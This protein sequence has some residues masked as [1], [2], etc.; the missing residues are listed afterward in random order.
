MAV[1][2]AMATVAS[3]AVDVTTLEATPY[4]LVLLLHWGNI[5]ATNEEFLKFKR[6]GAEHCEKFGGVAGRPQLSFNI[7]APSGILTILCV[8]K[9]SPPAQIPPAETAVTEFRDCPECPEMVVVPVGSFK[10]GDLSGGVNRNE[11]PVHQITFSRLFAVG[12]Y[13]VTFDQWDACVSD[14]GCKTRPQDE[15]WGRSNRPV[16][17]VSWNDAR[18]YV[19]WLSRKTGKPYRLLSEAEWEY[20]ARAGT[21]TE[22]YWGNSFS[23]DYVDIMTRRSSPVGSFLPNGFGLHDMSGNVNEWVQDCYHD[24]Y[25]GAP[26]DG[27]AWTTGDCDER[28][29]RG[30]GP[31]GRKSVRS[32]HRRWYPRD[33]GSKNIG[34]RAARTVDD[35]ELTEL[36]AQAKAIQKQLAVPQVGGGGDR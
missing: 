4:K 5:P 3:S 35:A 36:A 15:G 11:R 34:F 7:G 33:Y 18:E 26:I 13:E 20:A 30:G 23:Y 6:L 32:A 10:M 12:K 9:S 29:I 2:G 22:Y 17:H 28:V 31:G 8:G 14:G 25:K 24:S 27:T 19:D 21:T 1:I 16:I